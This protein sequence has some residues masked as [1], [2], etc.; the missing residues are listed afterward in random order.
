MRAPAKETTLALD[1]VDIGGKTFR[2]RARLESELSSWQ[3]QW[4]AP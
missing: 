4:R 1:A 3:V 2:S